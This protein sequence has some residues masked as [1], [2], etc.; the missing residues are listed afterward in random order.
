MMQLLMQAVPDDG[1][2]RREPERCIA[3]VRG[4]SSRCEYFE[5]HVE[6]MSATGWPGFVSADTLRYADAGAA[7]ALVE[8]GEEEA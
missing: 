1:P 7:E 6:G 2:A 8:P 5:P 4:V 3:T